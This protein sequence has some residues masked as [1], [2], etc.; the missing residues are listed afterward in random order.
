MIQILSIVK[1][2]SPP[3]RISEEGIPIPLTQLPECFGGFR[4]GTIRCNKDNAPVGSLK[5]TF[6]GL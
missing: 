5:S 3:S 1:V 4:R 2:V 6:L